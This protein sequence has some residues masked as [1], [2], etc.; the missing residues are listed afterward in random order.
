MK[1]VQVPGGDLYR[2]ALQYLG[3]ATQATRIAA[4]NGLTDFFLSGPT[5]LTIPN[6]DPSQTGGA[7]TL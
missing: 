1:V 3:D 5:T 6:V 2:I 7:S 4:L